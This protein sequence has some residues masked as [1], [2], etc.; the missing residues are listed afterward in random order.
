ARCRRR[1]RRRA[2]SRPIACEISAPVLA[3]SYRRGEGIAAP[4]QLL[5]PSKRLAHQPR[6][7]SAG[8]SLEDTEITGC[9]GAGVGAGE[10]ASSSE[11]ATKGAGSRTVERRRGGAGSKA[12]GALLCGGGYSAS[13]VGGGGS[14][15]GA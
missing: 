8:S 9:S 5:S 10:G 15:A 11:R 1:R 7:G 13:A 2:R 4:A 14:T 12:G 6:L 3:R